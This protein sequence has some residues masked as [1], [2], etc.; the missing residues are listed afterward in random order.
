MNKYLFVISV[1]LFGLSGAMPT[2]AQNSM[3]AAEASQM[4]NINTA[5]AETLSSTLSGIG[6]ARAQAIVLYR[7]QNGPFESVEELLEVEGVGEVILANN[8]H[9]LAIQ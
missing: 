7:E 2:L 8:R 4:I 9:L 3:P 1:F 6:M 5:S